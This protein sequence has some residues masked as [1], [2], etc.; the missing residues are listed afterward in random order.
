MP[1]DNA[2]LFNFELIQL[3]FLHLI[4]PRSGDKKSELLPTGWN[5]SKEL[6]TLRYKSNDDKSIFLVKAITVDSTLIFNLMVTIQ[7]YKILFQ[8]LSGYFSN[9]V[10]LHLQ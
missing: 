6:Y 7:L 2:Y 10:R 3:F 9:V 4:Q 5:G 1:H 8:I